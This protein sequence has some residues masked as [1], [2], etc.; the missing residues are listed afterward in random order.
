LW[1]GTDLRFVDQ[2]ESYSS[3]IFDK[4]VCHL[5]ISKFI[6]DKLSL[7]TSNI[8]YVDFQ[9]HSNSNLSSY[10]ENIEK[11]NIYIYTAPDERRQKLTYGFDLYNPL[12]EYFKHESFLIA[13]NKSYKYEE[14][15][16]IYSNIKL[17]LRLTYFDGNANTVQELA[18][19]G[20]Y[21]INNSG[22]L[23]S[24]PYI[25]D[26]E[27]LKS[28]IS[29]LLKNIKIPDKKLYIKSQIHKKSN[30]QIKNKPGFRYSIY[31]LYTD[32]PY[33]TDSIG[34]AAVNE[35]N[36]ISCLID[37][38][39]VYYNDIYINDCFDNNNNYLSEKFISKFR[40]NLKK[41]N[42]MIDFIKDKWNSKTLF[43]P[44]KDYDFCFYRA[45]GKYLL[46]KQIF[47]LLPEPKIWSHSYNEDVWK[48]NI[49]GFQTETA[50]I[51]A[52]FKYLQ[53]YKN[54]GTIGYD[55]E[56]VVPKRDNFIFYQSIREN[57][58]YIEKMDLKKKFNTS[59]L[60]C[61]IGTLYKFTYPW[62][63]LK[64][65]E[66][67]RE[68]YPEKN[69]SLLILSHTVCEDIPKKDYIHFINSSKELVASYLDSCDIV[70]D[71]WNNEQIIF[72][73]SNKLIDCINVGIPVITAKTFSHLEM[74]GNFYPLYHE[75]KHTEDYFEN[76]IENEIKSKIEKC[77]S[78]EY[79]R[80]VKRYLQGIKNRFNKNIVG[81]K[82]LIQFNEIYNKKILITCPD[83]YVGGVVTYT[84]N[85]IKS[86]KNYDL[87]LIIENK[88]KVTDEYYNEIKSHVT[89]ICYNDI[90]ENNIY[91]DTIICN[92]SPSIK[93]N[94]CNKIMNKFNETTSNLCYVTHN[95]VSEANLVIKEYHQ[96]I[97]KIIT[98]NKLT[99]EKLSSYL[100]IDKERF[101]SINPCGLY[102]NKVSPKNKINK[103]IGYF[104]R[105]NEIK[106]PQFLLKC[107]DSI[108]EKF[109]EWKLYIVGPQ[110]KKWHY[111]DMKSY[112]S[113]SKNKDLLEKN[114]I[115]V[116]KNITDEEEKKYYY[117]LFDIM[118]SCT[119]IEGFPYVLMESFQCG[120]PVI[121]TNVGGNKDCVI[122]E[123]NGDILNFKGLY[124]DDIYHDNIYL[125]LI[126]QMYDNEEY[127][128]NEFKGIV[129]KYLNDPKKILEMSPNCL[130]TIK[131]RY[132]K[133]V[134]KNNFYKV[135]S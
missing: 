100:K 31:I 54:D 41:N 22:V 61:I 81:Q 95:D 20:I 40:E 133:Y 128:I 134:F 21:T 73:G 25:E 116:N 62:S 64:I 28:Q 72:G 122:P 97:D 59:F 57:N 67:L 76:E 29:Y 129:E 89:T 19:N 90:V 92:S 77:F 75:F 11:E 99:A 10:L 114:V 34:G 78:F 14:M 32:K 93:N 135:I 113:M 8:Y 127:N 115:F 118:I 18:D 66:E 102:D 107:F 101:I 39:D 58:I 43:Y 70:I 84:I 121:I 45:P 37:S 131:Y 111:N 50:S 85:I 42:N 17:G 26:V 9:M 86:L 53:N 33:L 2:I 23:G 35:I 69:I 106:Q 65:I 49:V 6:F 71:T 80:K 12:V 56:M 36:K 1:G 24:I 55:G 74:M 119:T 123:K 51:L 125:D 7:F 126:K 110:T 104:G 16:E 13:N 82:Y 96:I 112:I 94:N 30:Y 109:P 47:D 38:C 63:H 91:F 4:N 105:V 68:K 132:S 5:C 60:I 52:N 88:N 44:S 87:Y 98:V 130:N 3:F 27:L 120:T 79:R 124:V 108:V 48:N 117:N 15:K 103:I 83:L 46:F